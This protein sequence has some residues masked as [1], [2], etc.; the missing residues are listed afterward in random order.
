MTDQE[1][2]Q[3]IKEGRTEAFE[4]LYA[5]HRQHV[6]S[7]CSHML[8]D[9]TIAEDLM[10]EA[11]MH[12]FRKISSFRSEALFS[13]WLHRI[14]INTVLM[15]LRRLKTARFN[16][17]AECSLD[18]SLCDNDERTYETVLGK[19]DADLVSCVDR[20]ALLRAIAELAPGYR[21]I[22]VLH[23]I[24]GYEHCEIA[25]MLV[26]SIGTSKSQLHKARMRLRQLL[27]A[28]CALSLN[29]G[30]RMDSFEYRRMMSPVFHQPRVQSR[31]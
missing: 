25:A 31:K 11:F 1:A 14:V 16:R 20:V 12:A 4:W 2:I 10:Q 30:G 15:H 5:N 13:T 9:R 6:Y 29:R 19:Q 24:E 8:R 7:T 18:A 26:C 28:W 27:P 23:D 17:S 22:F 3:A 21:M